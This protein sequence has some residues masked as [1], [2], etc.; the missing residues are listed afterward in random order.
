MIKKFT[1]KDFKSYKEANLHITPLSI[2]I[3]A[4]ASGKSNMLEALRLLNWL[5]QG[6]KLSA[7]QYQI[8]EEDQIVRGFINHLP[9]FNQTSFSLGCTIKE[10][11]KSFKLNLTVGLRS[12]KDN[13]ELHIE[14]EECSNNGWLYRTKYPSQEDFTNMTLEFDNHRQG[15]KKPQIQTNDQQVSFLQLSSASFEPKYKKEPKEIL[16]ATAALEKTLSKI[17]FLD[18]NPKLMHGYSFKSDKKLLETGKNISAVLHH[19]IDDD[20]NNKNEILQFIKSLPEQQIEDISFED[21]SRGEVLVQLH[22][23]F[24][25]GSGNKVDAGLLSDGTLRALAIVAAL[26]SADE[27]SLVIIEEIDNGIHPNR[28]KDLMERINELAKRR[29]LSVLI[30]SHNPTLLNASPNETIPNV[31]F[32]YRDSHDGC[33][34]I[35]RIQEIKDYPELIV[36][37]D[38]GNLL[39]RGLIDQYVKDETT[40]EEKVKK[41]LDWLKAFE[42]E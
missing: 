42:D 26:L 13:W 40:K 27:G 19:L 31:Q 35:T 41:G 36:Q 9:R 8:N 6:Q 10:K 21:T 12:I 34:K 30:T 15:G 20:E 14:H 39:T 37:D 1:I 22:E 24:Q 3:G 11:K 4:N 29:G 16:A 33:S 25:T 2:L 38:L 23:A 32:C 28:V 17:V 7:L 18:P 5:A